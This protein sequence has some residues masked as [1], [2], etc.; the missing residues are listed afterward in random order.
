M[1]AI[2]APEVSRSSTYEIF[3]TGQDFSQNLQVFVRC[4]PFV[5]CVL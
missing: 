3:D 1:A 2:M 4:F 5:V